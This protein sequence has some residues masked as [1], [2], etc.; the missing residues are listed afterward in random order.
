MTARAGEAAGGRSGGP[1]EPVRG[2]GAGPPGPPETRPVGGAR[3]ARAARN[4]V[5]GGAP[6][7]DDEAMRVRQ[8]AAGDAM[9]IAVVHVRSWQAA[10]RGLMPQ[11]Y[12]DGLD[13]VRRRAQWDRLLADGGWPR[14]GVLVAEIDGQ[15]A[16]FT[17]LSPARDES[18]DR[19][20]VAEIAAIYLAPEAW[21]TGV[22]RQLMG[23][24]LEA[25]ALA[26]YSQVILWVLDSNVRARRF[27]AAG[28]WQPDG[29]VKTDTRLGFPHTEVRYRR[30]LA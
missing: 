21:G 1:G 5:A 2:R 10:Y 7:G 25:L 9:A 28:G 24:A 23:A 3:A 29:A 26:G 27:Y 4:R 13:P 30:P 16:G 8:A 17:A 20:Q 19:A 14:A 18:E 15:I 6:G 22:G 12:L 11:D